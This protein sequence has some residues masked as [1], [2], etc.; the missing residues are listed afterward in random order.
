M[1]SNSQRKLLKSLNQKKYRK[2]YKLFPAEGVKIVNEILFSAL[3]IQSVFATADWLQD[4]SSKLFSSGIKEIVEVDE[5]ELKS[6]SNL[7]TPNKVIALIEI[8]E[9]EIDFS[10]DLILLLDSIRDPGNLGTIIRIAD[11]YNV[12]TIIC[13]EDCVDVYNT[14]V[15][16]ASMAS[17]IRTNVHYKDLKQLLT[18][19][20]SRHSYAAVLNGKSVHQLQFE[21]PSFLVIGNESSGIN[22]NIISMINHQIS[23]PKF[24]KAE[25]LNASVA[26]G[27]ILDNMRRGV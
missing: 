17:I 11:W 12:K 25:S 8:H 7:S 2:K 10:S 19:Q 13:S 5:V 27:I 6:I 21:K 1:I 4:K 18:S 23:I 20:T 26:A 22:E 16:Q 9:T 15:I 14:K 3:K 24:G